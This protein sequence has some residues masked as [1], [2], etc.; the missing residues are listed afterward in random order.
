MESINT[1]ARVG[2]RHATA[3]ACVFVQMAAVEAAE[4]GEI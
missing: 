2:G 1:K 3:K 4:V